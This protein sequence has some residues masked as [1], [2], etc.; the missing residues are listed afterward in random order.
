VSEPTYPL[1]KPGVFRTVQG[2]GVLLGVPM[3]FVRLA[4]CSVGCPECDTD[5]RVRSRATADDIARRVVEE[6]DGAEWVWVTGGEPTDHDL[7]PLVAAVKKYGFRVAL[8]TSGVKPVPRGDAAGVGLC[9]FDFV[10]VSPHRVDGSWVLRRG[11]QLNF[12]PELNG[13][14]WHAMDGV[15][16]S[17]FAHKFITPVWDNETGRARQVRDCADWLAAHRGWRLG[18]QAHRYWGVA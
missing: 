16:V 1:A 10:S 9:G 14:D 11:E 12:V 17:G 13:L 5:Y 8:A 7:A 15:D 4:G 2:E 18:I 3:V 6:A